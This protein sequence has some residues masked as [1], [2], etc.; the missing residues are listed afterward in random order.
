MGTFVT[1]NKSGT[2]G[3]FSQVDFES[4]IVELDRNRR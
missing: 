4:E 1:W 2:R 3:L